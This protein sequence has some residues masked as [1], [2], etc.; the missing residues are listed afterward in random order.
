MWTEPA[1]RRYL[2]DDVIIDRQCALD[3][4]RSMRGGESD[5]LGGWAVFLKADPGEMA[6]FCGFRY[7]EDRSD[8]ELMYGLRER[9]HGLGLATEV[10]RTLLDY[11]W[12]TT[13]FAR[14]LA[15]T[16][17]PNVKSI[18]VMQ[19]LGMTHRSTTDTMVTYVALR[20]ES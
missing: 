11:L 13:S 3:A 4:F 18:A 6:G 14:V 20:P 17:P 9:C 2:W 7:L 12:R 5:G 19:R 8:I 16:D 15:R 10:S 1:V